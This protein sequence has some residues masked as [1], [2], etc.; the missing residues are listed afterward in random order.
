MKVKRAQYR[1]IFLLAAVSNNCRHVGIKNVAGTEKKLM[2]AFRTIF[3]EFELDFAR[4][5]EGF[6]KG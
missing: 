5:I 4:K 1:A 6:I 3:G 2:L